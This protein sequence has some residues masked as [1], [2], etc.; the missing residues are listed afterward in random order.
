M[1]WMWGLTDCANFFRHCLGRST[2][3]LPAFAVGNTNWFLWKKLVWTIFM[4]SLWFSKLIKEDLTEVASEFYHLH[5][6]NWPFQWLRIL[7]Y[8]N[9]SGIN[10]LCLV[11]WFQ[12]ENQDFGMGRRQAHGWEAW[13]SSSVCNILDHSGWY[14]SLSLLPM[15][16]FLCTLSCIICS[17]IS[18]V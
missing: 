13:Q 1:V 7:V 18:L 15:L 9:S 5:L 6:V 12:C 11:K 4:S 16:L 17:K 8:T 2:G 10:P 3:C 14:C